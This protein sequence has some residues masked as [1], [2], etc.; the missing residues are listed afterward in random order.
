M[1]DR[2]KH[3]AMT[4][5]PSSDL[6]S[7][8]KAFVLHTRP[9][10]NT[11]LLIDFFTQTQGKI[12]LVAKSIRSPNSP[13][14]AAMHLFQPIS[15]SSYGRGNLKS[16]KQAEA[17]SYWGSIPN[18]KLPYA[19]YLNE[20]LYE[21]FEE[22][23]PYPYLFEAYGK[24]I[25]SL[26]DDSF[27]EASLRFFERDLLDSLGYGLPLTHVFQENTLLDPSLY[28]YFAFHQGLTPAPAQA[29]MEHP[30]L[31]CG[32]SLL[33]LHHGNLEDKNSLR[34][35]KRLL[36]YSLQQLTE[37]KRF[38]SRSLIFTSERGT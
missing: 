18:N 25:Q 26:I 31:F 4:N 17:I 11:S 20:L 5:D 35:A 30:L 27:Q 16:L 29:A 37:G 9:Y 15:I 1:S 7:I 32:K 13:L 33:D 8:G 12:T 28:Y 38:Y 3:S 10:R 6:S 36:R 21:L 14:K 23:D 34:D 24:L 2:S 22:H 19:F